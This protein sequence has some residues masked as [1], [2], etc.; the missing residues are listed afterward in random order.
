MGHALFQTVVRTATQVRGYVAAGALPALAA[1]ALSP[2]QAQGTGRA[3]PVAVRRPRIPDAWMEDEARV[4]ELEMDP[5]EYLDVK[6]PDTQQQHSWSHPDLSADPWFSDDGGNKLADD[7]NADSTVV[8]VKEGTDKPRSRRPIA[9]PVRAGRRTLDDVATH[10]LD[11]P[12]DDPL[13]I[14]LPPVSLSQKDAANKTRRKPYQR[15]LYDDDD[16]RSDA[17]STAATEDRAARRTR[18][19][20]QQGDVDMCVSQD[21]LSS[22]ATLRRRANTSR[23]GETPDDEDGAAVLVPVM[24]ASKQQ[25]DNVAPLWGVG[26]GLFQ[27]LWQTKND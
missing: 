26:L 22:P 9:M 24:P 5:E 18:R 23:L 7:T 13:L 8:A 19:A 17:G 21:G 12:T 25:L 20:R 3:S 1:A 14:P 10:L 15:R 2:E 27:S 11:L 6:H 16:V 4:E